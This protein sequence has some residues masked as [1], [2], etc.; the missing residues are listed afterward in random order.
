MSDISNTIIRSYER[1]LK[2]GV[3]R[4]LVRKHAKIRVRTL[5]RTGNDDTA[6]K[7]DFWINS[8]L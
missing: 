3:S 4:E 5:K 1:D 7:V 8:S 6:A 2:A